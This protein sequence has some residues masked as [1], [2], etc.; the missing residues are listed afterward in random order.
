M[1]RNW[2]RDE[3]ILTFNLYC[4]L[5]FGK[6]HRLNPEIIN[7][8]SIINRTPSAVALKLVNFA[9]LDPELKKRGIKGMSSHSKLDK[10]IF[11]EFSNDWTT[12]LVESELLLEEYNSKEGSKNNNTEIDKYIPKG[13][14]K[15]VEVKQ[16]VNQH[17]F[18]K[19]VLSNYDETCIIC[20]LNHPKLLVASH[21]IPW[22]KNKKE[23]LTPHNGICLCS[24]HDKSFD[25]G[26]I[27]IDGNLKL[28][29]SKELRKI[30][31]TSFKSFFENYE[32]KVLNLPKKFYPSLEFLNFHNKKIFLGA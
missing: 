8:S 9:S 19:M 13:I 12:L 25:T 29:I 10:I 28:L 14:D 11:T 22:A 7:L 5:P 2:I 20:K 24:I 16:R 3:L 1:R 32:N 21:I 31:N 30:N 6:L 27:S 4:K 23:R 15:I 26:L 17:L 18:R